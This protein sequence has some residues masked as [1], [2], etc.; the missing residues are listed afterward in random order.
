MLEVP[1]QAPRD[2]ELQQYLQPT[3]FCEPDHPEIQ[4]VT[5]KVI[6]GTKTPKEAA[7]RIY[8][9]VRDEIK[10]GMTEPKSSIEVLHDKVGYCWTKPNL[11]VA[12]LRAVKIP[13]R[14]RA[15]TY[16]PFALTLAM[17]EEFW[18]FVWEYSLSMGWLKFILMI[19][20]SVP[21]QQLIKI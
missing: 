20:G 17:P 7:I 13:A 6:E 5:A 18:E 16:Q 21:M 11:Q 14:Y 3:E 2:P 10:F 9:F 19:N 15:E 1:W 4:Q 8:L 12:M